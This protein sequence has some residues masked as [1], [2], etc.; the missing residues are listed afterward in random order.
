VIGIWRLAAIKIEDG[1]IV[2]KLPLSYSNL[3]VW[4]NVSI[5]ARSSA[6]VHLFSACPS[7]YFAIQRVNVCGASLLRALGLATCSNS[8]MRLGNGK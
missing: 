6:L 4:L 3:D 2:P 8:W 1:P 7:I 5:S